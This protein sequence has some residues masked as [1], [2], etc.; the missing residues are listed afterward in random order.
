[1][2]RWRSGL[3]GANDFEPK[4]GER[5]WCKE[6]LAAEAGEEHHSHNNCTGYLPSL[7]YSGDNECEC[8]CNGKLT[9]E[10]R[11]ALRKLLAGVP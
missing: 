11:F 8:P 2:A 1:M 10:E 4:K 7:A 5:G 6:C 3:F 9:R